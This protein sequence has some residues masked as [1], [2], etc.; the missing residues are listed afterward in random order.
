MGEEAFLPPGAHQAGWP[1]PLVLVDLQAAGWPGGAL[2]SEVISAPLL[3]DIIYSHCGF[4]LR[5]LVSASLL[6]G[7][8]FKSWSF[9]DSL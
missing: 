5:P 2:G 9:D 6:S 3:L 4:F 7:V 8:A 1:P